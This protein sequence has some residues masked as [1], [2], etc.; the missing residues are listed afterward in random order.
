[1]RVNAFRPIGAEITGLRINQIN[2]EVTSDLRQL[3]ADNGV[4]V[5]PGQEIDDAGFVDFLAQ[6]GRLTFSQGETPVQGF[7]DLNV[8]SNVGRSTPPRSV[9]HIDTSYVR[10]PPA[11]TALRAVEIPAGGGETLFSNQYRAFETLPAEVSGRLAGRT[12]TH[13]VTGLELPA[14]AETAADHPVFLRH[15]VSGRTALYLSTPQRCIAIS[16]IPEAEARELI[17]FLYLH[18]TAEDNTY[19]HSW[20]A[21]DVVIWDNRCVMHRADHAAVVGDRVMH[22]GMV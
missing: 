15:P 9:F 19:R 6:F 13:V 8:I 4:V 10:Q 7:P 2:P 5:L 21:G 16:G 1:M 11:Y 18:S 22:R 3:L 17:E 12:M 14:D 20:S